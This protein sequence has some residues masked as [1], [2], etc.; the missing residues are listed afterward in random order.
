MEIQYD[1]DT[2]VSGAL[3]EV[4]TFTATDYDDMDTFAWSLLGTDEAY[5]EIDA[6]SGTLTFRQDDGFGHGPLPNFEFPR[7]DDLGDGSSNTYSITVR[8][9]DDDATDSKSTDY[10]VIVAVTDVNEVPELVGTIAETVSHDE[11]DAND[12]YVVMDLA[13]YDAYDEE[14]GV[15]WSLTGTDRSDFDISGDGVLTFAQ[16]PNYEEP[17]GLRRRQRVRVHR[18]RHRRPERLQTPQRQRPRDGHRWRRGRGRRHR[19]GQPESGG[20]TDRDIQADRPG[21]RHRHLQHR[22]HL[23]ENPITGVRGIMD[24]GLRRPHPRL[25]DLPLDR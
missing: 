19:G 8:A 23:L 20:G 18:G 16:T 17:E 10:A 1:A 12:A 5:L 11:H 22:H 2:T 6:T 15:T 13:D 9:T 14:G 21:R 25:D 4:H 7:D 24:D 3:P